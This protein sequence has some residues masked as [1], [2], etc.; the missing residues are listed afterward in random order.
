MIFGQAVGKMNQ[1]PPVQWVEIVDGFIEYFCFSL[2]KLPDAWIIKQIY[3]VIGGI[4]NVVMPVR[5]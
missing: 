3:L 2:G 4:G 5:C 1:R